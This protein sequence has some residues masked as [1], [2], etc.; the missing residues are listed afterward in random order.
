[1]IKRGLT[2]T[3]YLLLTAFIAVTGAF[4]GREN[5]NI[6]CSTIH[7]SFENDD[8]IRLSQEEIV[9]MV[10]SA[11]NQLIGKDL[12]Q[13]NAE[14]IELEVEKH[15]AIEA[16]EV[17]KVRIKADSA[18]QGVLGVRVKHREPVLRIMS[19]SGSY[20]LDRTG[21]KIPVSSAYAARV[22][23]ASGDFT[24]DYARERLLPFYHF[25]EGNSFWR[26][27][28]E[29][30]HIESNGEVV[31]TPLVGNHLIEMGALDGYEQKLSHLKNFYEQVMAGSN[32]E[33]Y[34]RISLKYNNQIIAK[35]R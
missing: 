23:V 12:R 11:D 26:A 34:R 19:S 6:P 28:I 22:L 13:I 35:K 10:R 24:D 3:G 4:T 33:M 32:W 7:V 18:Y 20:Y 1:M 29:Q 9:R 15:Q 25:L 17:Y 30:V 21:E 16:A 5:R 31:L 27:Q 2:W 14:Q 8:L